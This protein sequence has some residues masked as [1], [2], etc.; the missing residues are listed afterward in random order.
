MFYY[1]FWFFDRFLN[2]FLK[3][4]NKKFN[5]NRE[6]III[7]FIRKPKILRVRQN[8]TDTR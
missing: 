7:F 1:F 2:K 5:R 4:T 8:G 3:Q 6:K